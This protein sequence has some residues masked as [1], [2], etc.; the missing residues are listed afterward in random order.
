MSEKTFK[1]EVI[2]PDRKVL[3]DK[4]IVSVIIP[5]VSGYIG[6]LANH[7]PLM[8]ELKIGEIDFKRSD[9]S[10]DCMAVSGGFVEV[11]ENSVTVLAE[12]AELCEEIDVERAESALHRAEERLSHKEANIDIARA[13]AALKRALNRLN[14]AKH[15]R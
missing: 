7:A 10:E 11:F 14:V 5:G 12:S 2:T 4:S 13:E 15:Q 8:T 3:V 1:L 6:I 9:G